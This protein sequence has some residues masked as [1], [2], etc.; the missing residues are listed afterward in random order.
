MIT[1]HFSLMVAFLSTSLKLLSNHVPSSLLG[2][3]NMTIPELPK[4]SGSFGITVNKGPVLL[5]GA[6]F[7]P[8]FTPSPSGKGS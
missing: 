1:R 7:L 4:D 5:L 2:I 6:I 3:G 8:I